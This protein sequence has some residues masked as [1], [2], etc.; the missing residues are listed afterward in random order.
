MKKG[1]GVNL[2]KIKASLEIYFPSLSLYSFNHSSDMSMDLKR[3]S[4]ETT[5]FDFVVI[6]Q[7]KKS[8]FSAPNTKMKTIKSCVNK[9][10]NRFNL[11]EE[12]H[13]FWQPVQKSNARLLLNANDFSQLGTV[14][15][16]QITCNIFIS[17]EA[18]KKYNLTICGPY[19]EFLDDFV[20]LENNVAKS[21]NVVVSRKCLSTISEQLSILENYIN[22]TQYQE[23][24]PG[25]T[26]EKK[27]V[28]LPEDKPELV[29]FFSHLKTSEQLQ[30]IYNGY[31]VYETLLQKFD[32]QK[33]KMH[34]FLHEGTSVPEGESMEQIALFEEPKEKKEA[35]ATPDDRSLR[36]DVNH[37]DNSLHFI[38]Y[39]NAD[40]I[41]PGNCTFEFSSSAS[42]VYSIKMGPHEIGPKGQKELW[43]FPSLSAPLV[44]YT[45]KIIN[46]NGDVIFI[47][48]CTESNEV[49][50]KS[51]L[52]SFSTGSFHTLQDPNNVFRADALSSFDESSVMSSPFPNEIDE[53]YDSGSTLNRPF[54][55][56]EI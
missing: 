13:I 3:I 15:H 21:D 54:T 17:E 30:E 37:E 23:A 41:V 56:E 36:V 25:K 9:F 28:V 32:G 18:L 26:E 27:Y 44:D 35:L 1:L 19:D 12:Q 53:I 46:Q 24:G 47:G 34:S 11:Y 52:S 43:Y 55:W 38:L 48:K 8:A 7:F 51:A 4:V 10:I 50:L 2:K 49:T 29:E 31:R 33:E 40:L 42:K 6:D 45:V 14:L 39:N 5:S 22:K 20:P 16:R